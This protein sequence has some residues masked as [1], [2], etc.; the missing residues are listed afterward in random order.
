MNRNA[1]RFSDATAG[2]IRCARWFHR[3]GREQMDREWNLRLEERMRERV[4]IAGELHD[5]LFQ[6]F[7]GVSMQLCHAADQ[8]PADSPAKPS[9]TRAQRLMQRVLDEGRDTLRG[10]HSSEAKCMSL[11]Q[12]LSVLSAEFPPD[13][14]VRLRVFVKGQPKK[15]RPEIQ[16]QIYLIGREAMLNALCHAHATT[17][18][19]EV[20]YLFRGLRVAVR[21][22]GCGINPQIL[23]LGHAS[24]RG[25]LRMRERAASIGAQLQIWSRPGSGTE[26]AIS[27]PGSVLA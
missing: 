27:L 8:V 12:A 4:R 10:L 23:Q 7:L 2:L 9:L 6:G 16:Q 13:H 5:T 17:I 26:V 1:K 3:P 11:E 20:G 19:A 24:H 14:G 22:D 25:L 15:L 21:D 18:E